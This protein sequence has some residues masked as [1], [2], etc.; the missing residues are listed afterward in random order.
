MAARKTAKGGH[1]S[2]DNPYAWMSSLAAAYFQQQQTKAP[3]PHL[4]L[5]TANKT[6]MEERKEEMSTSET[7][8]PSGIC[9][10][11]NG[12]PL[13]THGAFQDIEEHLRMLSMGSNALKGIGAMMLPGTNDADEATTAKR[14][15]LSEIFMFF[16]EVMADSA[17][18]VSDA[19]FRIE[20]AAD[21][22]P[23]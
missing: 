16:G 5:V 9:R 6:T 13:S 12:E 19:V 20:Q 1:V 23:S 18:F 15:E 8:Q 21:G 22:R 3:K 17:Q 14:L 7:Q 4:T 2:A 11:W 10:M